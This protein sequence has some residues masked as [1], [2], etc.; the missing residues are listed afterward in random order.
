LCVTP[1][2]QSPAP[3]NKQRQKQRHLPEEEFTTGKFPGAFNIMMDGSGG[4]FQA[5]G[6]CYLEFTPSPHLNTCLNISISKVETLED[7]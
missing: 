2:I 7:T 3:E 1:S 4:Q 6:L 5:M